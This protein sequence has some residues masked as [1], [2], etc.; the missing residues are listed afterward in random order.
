[1]IGFDPTPSLAIPADDDYYLQAKQEPQPE[2]H[3]L[4]ETFFDMGSLVSSRLI[5]THL[6]F[7]F[8]TL[9]IF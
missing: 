8:F 7:F 5:R 2:Y 9:R 4:L 3:D 6:F 1:M